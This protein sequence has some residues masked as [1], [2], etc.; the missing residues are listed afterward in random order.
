[1]PTSHLPPIGERIRAERNRTGQ[2]V[3]ALAGAA[4]VSA[5]LI[6]QI[7]TAKAQPSVSTLYAIAG[8]LGIGVEDLLSEDGDGHPQGSRVDDTAADGVRRRIGPVVR[9]GEQEVIELESGVTWE[10]LGQVPGVHTEFLRVTYP[11]GASSS[12]SERLMRHPGTEYGYLL[13]GELVL[14]LGFE[15][16]LLGP[17]DAI[18]FE[19]PTPHSYRNDGDEPAVGIWFVRED[20][21]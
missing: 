8:A 5:S 2:T 1:M 18:C 6:S 13:S 19:S 11:P 12:S 20:Q 16:H 3:R 15:E 9:A 21:P 7:E 17:G 10:M 4:G 14:T